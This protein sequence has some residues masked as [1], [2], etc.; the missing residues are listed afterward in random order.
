MAGTRELLGEGSQIRRTVTLRELG[1]TGD[2][3]GPLFISVVVF[4]LAA[5]TGIVVTTPAWYVLGVGR[6]FFP[7][8]FMPVTAFVLLLVT[9]A[10]LSIAWAGATISFL[11]LWEVLGNRTTFASVRLF[12]GLS[13]LIIWFL[14][15]TFLHIFATPRPELEIHLLGQDLALHY[16]LY[17]FHRYYDFM[18]FVL[19]VGALGMFWGYGEGLLRNRVAQVVTPVLIWLTFYSLSLTIGLHAATVG[20]MSL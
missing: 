18:H 20:V 2:A 17:T 9:T 16:A 11:G 7:D 4:L 8:L 15:A 5:V 19:A 1:L 12:T 14:V 13:L 6:P 3:W 10:A